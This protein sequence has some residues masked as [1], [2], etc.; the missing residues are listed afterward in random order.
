MECLDCW[1]YTQGWQ[2]DRGSVSVG[3]DNHHERVCLRKEGAMSTTED[4]FFGL[5]TR[6][7]GAFLLESLQA[8]RTARRILPNSSRLE[9]WP[10]RVKLQE[11]ARGK[12]HKALRSKQAAL[13]MAA[14]PPRKG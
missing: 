12:L 14:Q 9:K 8:D 1:K 4:R 10:I 6:Q 3:S 2:A 11:A 7:I 13:N 5:N